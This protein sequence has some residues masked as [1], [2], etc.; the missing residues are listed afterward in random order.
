MSKAQ[1]SSMEK[2]QTKWDDILILNEPCSYYLL[3][4]TKVVSFLS[5]FIGLKSNQKRLLNFYKE[6]ALALSAAAEPLTNLR[7][8]RWL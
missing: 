5:L 4:E 6:L 2:D 1:S 8:V 7:C 3:Q